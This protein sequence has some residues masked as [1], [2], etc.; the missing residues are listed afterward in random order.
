[1][2]NTGQQ[3]AVK[4]LCKFF[5]STTA[6]QFGV[7]GLAGTGKSWSLAQFLKDNHRVRSEA[8]LLAPTHRAKN[9]LIDF[10]SEHHL[11]V[12]VTTIHSALGLRVRQVNGESLLVEGDSQ[13]IVN[14]RYVFVDE[15]SMIDEKL[16]RHLINWVTF[17]RDRKLVKLGDRLQLP[18]VSSK[19]NKIPFIDNHPCDFVELNQIERYKEENLLEIVKASVLATRFGNCF[20]PYGYLN[21]FASE[22]LKNISKN[23]VL[24]EFEPD[25]TIVAAWQNTTV[26]KYNFLIRNKVM[27]LPKDAPD[28]IPDEII[29]TNKTLVVDGQIVATNGSRLVV[30]KVEETIHSALHS[31]SKLYEPNRGKFEGYILTLANPELPIGSI[32]YEMSKVKVS[33]VKYSE[34]K[35][36]RAALKRIKEL[37]IESGGKA[38]REYYKLL[39]FNADVR[40]VYAG[41]IHSLQGSTYDRVI[42]RNDFGRFKDSFV[43][44][45]LWYV[46]MSRCREFLAVAS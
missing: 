25:K 6:Q 21:K 17:S 5:E 40:H 9:V 3:D 19:N 46:G 22:N 20:T 27:G 14:Y 11:G 2:L 41:T 13:P 43:Q 31:G 1:M 29:V 44:P 8:L 24:D 39:E 12:D 16:C 4:S 38:W 32:E 23:Q 45:R 36:Y 42:I 34:M 10:V 33:T 15:A 37:A 35:S 26:Q 30:D 28:F 18:P 7:Y